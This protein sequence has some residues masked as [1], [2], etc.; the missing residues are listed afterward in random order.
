MPL[1]GLNSG[2]RVVEL[3]AMTVSTAIFTGAAVS[4]GA[5][6]FVR[7]NWLLSAGSLIAGSVIGFL[8][9]QLVGLIFYRTGD[10]TTVVKAGSSSLFSTIPAGLLGGV[11]SALVVGFLALLVLGAVRQAGVFLGIAV[12]CGIS[13]GVLFACLG[14]LL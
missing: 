10:N 7:K 11:A 13:I 4:A 14:S 1:Q 12:G 9:G 8:V 6:W 2:D 5:V 3:S